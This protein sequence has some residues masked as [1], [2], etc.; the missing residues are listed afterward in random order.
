MG[1]KRDICTEIQCLDVFNFPILGNAQTEP[2]TS[3]D[4]LSHEKTQP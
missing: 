3:T 2:C 1:G 4:E